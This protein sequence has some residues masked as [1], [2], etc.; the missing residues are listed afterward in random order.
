LNRYKYT[1]DGEEGFIEA[2]TGAEAFDVIRLSHNKL[3]D[4]LTWLDEIKNKVHHGFIRRMESLVCV[5]ILKD[6]NPQTADQYTRTG[7]KK[8]AEQTIIKMLQVFPEYKKELSQ[9][10]LNVSERINKLVKE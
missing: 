1:L 5:I 3:P 2:E 9:V 8:D 6:L 4:T 7:L 10:Y